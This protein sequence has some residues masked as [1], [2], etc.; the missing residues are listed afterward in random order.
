K[1]DL[2]KAIDSLAALPNSSQ[3][4]EHSIVIEIRSSSANVMLEIESTIEI[5]DSASPKQIFDRAARV[6]LKAARLNGW[7]DQLH[8]I[9]GGA[10]AS[11]NTTLGGTIDT[12]RIVAVGGCILGLLIALGGGLLTANRIARPI[13]SLRSAAERLGDGDFAALD[14]ERRTADEIGDLLG[15]FQQ[16]AP[17]LSQTQ[18]N[19]TRNDRLSAP[20]HPAGSVAHHL[21]NPPA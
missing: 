3:A 12:L 17:K 18:A 16:T 13:Q 15:A 20:A 2:A 11:A 10:R 5:L 21:P 7:I 9:S 6:Q 19:L 4:R 1:D 14:G 8:S